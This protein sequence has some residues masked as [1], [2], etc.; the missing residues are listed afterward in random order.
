MYK[1]LALKSKTETPQSVYCDNVFKVPG[2]E[3]A[4]VS[5]IFLSKEIVCKS[6]L[7]VFICITIHSFSSSLL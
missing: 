2:T 4:L 7:C 3:Y 1:Y 5:L 6:S